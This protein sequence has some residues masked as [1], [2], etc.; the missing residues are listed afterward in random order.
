MKKILWVA[1]MTITTNELFFTPHFFTFAKGRQMLFFSNT[2]TL[3][4]RKAKIFGMHSIAQKLNEVSYF[5]SPLGSSVSPSE[6]NSQLFL[7]N[8]YIFV[9]ITNFF[10]NIPKISSSNFDLRNIL[11]TY[12]RIIFLYS[13]QI[14]RENVVTLGSRALSTKN[15]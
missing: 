15:D 6:A 10:L 13:L 2:C 5:F 12:H 4:T 3:A 14:S 11:L 7:D 8:L 1:M 9:I